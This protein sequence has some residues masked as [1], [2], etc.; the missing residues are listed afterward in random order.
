[1]VKG[2]DWVSK[3]DLV[4]FLR[5]PYAFWLLDTGQVRFRDTVDVLT[6]RLLKQGTVFHEGVAREAMPLPRDTDI[7][8][9]IAAD[10]HVIGF[11]GFLKNRAYKI[12]GRP[13]GVRTAHGALLPIEIK[14]HREV[15]RLDELELAFYWMLLEPLRTNKTIDPTGYVIARVEGR[16]ETI[17]VLLK[18]RRFD[19]VLR[20][21]DSIR[22]ARQDGVTPMICRCSV[23][24]ASDIR[25][26]IVRANLEG[27][28]LTLIHGIGRYFAGALE[29]QGIQT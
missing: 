2:R 12:L 18:P 14:S 28:G 27:K 19:E 3:T 17:E 25:G 29:A 13:D 11:P 24:S 21:L 5:C 9:L 1:M 4:T 20:T 22:K 7:S 26:E 10:H 15:T 16:P 6:A 23:C 8:T